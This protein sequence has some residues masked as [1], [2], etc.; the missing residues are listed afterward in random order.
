[1][2]PRSTFGFRGLVEGSKFPARRSVSENGAEKST[3]AK[4]PTDTYT[5]KTKYRYLCEMRTLSRNDFMIYFSG[6]NVIQWNS[7]NAT[8][9]IRGN[10][11]NEST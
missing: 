11:I 3:R 6:V 7:G 1:M 4:G 8:V 2:Q 10:L 5:C 9:C